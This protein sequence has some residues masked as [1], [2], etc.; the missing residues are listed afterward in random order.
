M[1]GEVLHKPFGAGGLALSRYFASLALFT[2]IAVCILVFRQR[3][4]AAAHGEAQPFFRSARLCRV[5]PKS[6]PCWRKASSGP[7]LLLDPRMAF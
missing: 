3:A 1:V 6:K 4:A 2:L 5:P 7:C